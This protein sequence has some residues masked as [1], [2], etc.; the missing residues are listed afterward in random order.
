MILEIDGNGKIYNID[1]DEYE[2]KDKD[3]KYLT[4]LAYFNEEKERF[5]ILM[6]RRNYN[7]IVNYGRSKEL[8]DYGKLFIRNYIRAEID[9]FFLNRIKILFKRHIVP[10]FQAIFYPVVIYRDVIEVKEFARKEGLYYVKK[11]KEA[12]AISKEELKELINS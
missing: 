8:D 9:S 3:I 4:R 12:R 2:I 10:I 11:I 5:Y 1:D 6:N 7:K